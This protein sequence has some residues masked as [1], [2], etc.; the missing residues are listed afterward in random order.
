MFLIP[1]ERAARIFP[2]PFWQ[3]RLQ[4]T[5]N[6]GWRSQKESQETARGCKQLKGR[7]LE[8]ELKRAARRS[9][10]KERADAR[11]MFG[12]EFEAAASKGGDDSRAAIMA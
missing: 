8:R 11:A 3:K 6:K 10:W 1:K 9:W 5:E 2:P 7:K 4:V 12:E